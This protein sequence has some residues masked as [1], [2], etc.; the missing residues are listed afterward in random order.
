MNRTASSGYD[1]VTAM[2][3][4]TL[5]LTQKTDSKQSVLMSLTGCD[6]IR[7]GASDVAARIPSSAILRVWVATKRAAKKT[8]LSKSP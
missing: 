1:I 2:A 4:A 7:G 3:G 6:L 8:V 5:S